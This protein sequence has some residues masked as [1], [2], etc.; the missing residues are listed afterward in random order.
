LANQISKALYAKFALDNYGEIIKS[1]MDYDTA[2]E[3][4]CFLLENFP[5]EYEEAEKINLA[6]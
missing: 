5:K 1:N 3:K 4:R 2:L 6:R